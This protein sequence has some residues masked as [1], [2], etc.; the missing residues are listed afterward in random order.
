[1]PPNCMPATSARAATCRISLTSWRSSALVLDHGGDETQAVAGLLHDAAEDHGGRERLVDIDRRFGR[2]VADIVEMC[3]DSLVADRNQKPP[4]WP[5]KVAYVERFSNLPHDSPALIV[6]AA[7]KLHNARSLLADYREV[8]EELWLRFNRTSGRAGQ[9]WYYGRLAEVL[10]ERM[11]GSRGSVLADD[12][13]R[14][15]TAPCAT[16]SSHRA[17]P[18]STRS[19]ASS[20][21]RA[22]RELATASAE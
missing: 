8:G 2:P 11:A 15:V 22:R 12:L 10:A 19:S 17:P 14:T 20:N 21:W 7:D 6:A 1:M 16:R 18:I 9:R 4:W 13:A 5:R 3:S